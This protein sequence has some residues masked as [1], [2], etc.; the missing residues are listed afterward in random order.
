MKIKYLWILVFL[1]T[2]SLQAQKKYIVEMTSSSELPEFEELNGVQNYIGKKEKEM[3]FFNKKRNFKIYRFNEYSKRENVL[4]FII[5]DAENEDF[6]KQL[7]KEFP[8]KYLVYEDI[9]DRWEPELL[10]D[11]L[12]KNGKR[13]FEKIN[14]SSKLVHPLINNVAVNAPPYEPN[15]YLTIPDSLT[16]RFDFNVFDRNDLNYLDAPKAWGILGGGGDPDIIIGISDAKVDDELPDL[17]NKV[18][19]INYTYGHLPVDIN[20]LERVHG[21]SVAGVAAAAGDNNDSSLGVCY[22]C[23]MRATNHGYANLTALAQSGVPVINMSWAYKSSL[24]PKQYATTSFGTASNNTIREIIDDY[25]TILVA[26]A[27]NYQ[28]YNLF[29]GQNLPSYGYPA[30]FD[31]VISVSSVHYRRDLA[32]PS[33]Y[34]HCNT[35][36][37]IKFYIKGAWASALDVSGIDPVPI[38][39]GCAGGWTPPTPFNNYEMGH[40]YNENVDIVAAGYGIL[41][42]VGTAYGYHPS[43]KYLGGTSMAAPL[44]TGTIG[45]MLSR[46]KCLNYDEVNDILK[47]SANSVEY[48]TFNSWNFGKMGG[49]SLQIGD[50]VQFVDEMNKWDGCVV[51]MEQTFNRFDLSALRIRNNLVIRETGFIENSVAYFKAENEIVL[52]NNTLIEPNSNGSF[53]IEI[54]EY[55][56]SLECSIRKP[57]LSFENKKDAKPI[58]EQVFVKVY[59]NPTSNILNV[60]SE[61]KIA[62]YTLCNAKG[63]IVIQNRFKSQGKKEFNFMTDRLPTGIYFLNIRLVNGEQIKKTVIKD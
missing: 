41:S 35:G 30:S 31:N 20:I 37:P 12:P 18:D 51:I 13:S 40:T 14:K 56:I 15:D 27:G 25:G 21:T 43:G 47:L 50:A 9:T 60:A 48:L 33:T 16:D 62:S 8:S 7:L 23:N 58:I 28:T 59:P 22:D 45:L 6:V 55:P 32:A 52:G 3:A 54:E 1:C 57:K 49:G 19:F 17:N 36:N 44:V 11:E 2:L 29:T 4:K 34:N 46:D 53:L 61:E 38:F 5:I 63:V 42:L 39:G 26:G 10:Y 24:N